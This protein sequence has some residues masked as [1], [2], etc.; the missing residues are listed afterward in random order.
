MASTG[1]SMNNNT[2]RRKKKNRDKKDFSLNNRMPKQ[3]KT[4][5]KTDVVDMSTG[6]IDID[7][8]P[9]VA[10]WNKEIYIKNDTARVAVDRF[11]EPE[12]IQMPPTIGMGLRDRKASKKDLIIDPANRKEVE[13]AIESRSTLKDEAIDLSQ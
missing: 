10:T 13:E 4:T 9:D 11:H 2:S 5:P 6:I 1:L 3:Q 12:E 7:N 8:T